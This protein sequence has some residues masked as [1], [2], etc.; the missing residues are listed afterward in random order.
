MRFT[1]ELYESGLIEKVL[2]HMSEL[3]PLEETSRL[4]GSPVGDGRL[5]QQVADMVLEQRW[6]RGREG[7]TYIEE[8]KSCTFVTYVR[9]LALDIAAKSVVVATIHTYVYCA[10]IMY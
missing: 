3:Q 10:C 6:E 5:I 9:K 2:Q 8:W 4:K 7:W 1:D